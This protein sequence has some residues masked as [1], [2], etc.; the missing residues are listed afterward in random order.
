MSKSK[1]AIIVKTDS[2]KVLV[3]IKD[4]TF[5]TLGRALEHAVN[6]DGGVTFELFEDRPYL[7]N[8][9]EYVRGSRK[10]NDFIEWVRVPA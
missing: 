2:G 7:W 10:P 9:G 3:E 6:V 1:L 8:P 5:L 4:H